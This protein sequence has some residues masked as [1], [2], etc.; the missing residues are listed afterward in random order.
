M[1]LM[2]D[3]Q[4]LVDRQQGQELPEETLRSI[5]AYYQRVTTLARP[6]GHL[7]GAVMGIGVLT[8]LIETVRSGE[9]R[10]V[11]LISL[12]LFGAPALLALL[13]VYPNAVRLGSRADSAAR[14]SALARA[15]HRDHLLCL[16]AML[17]FVA[18]QLFAALR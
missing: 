7:V 5:A 6:M 15:I 10:G 8:L 11:V 2:F 13:R 17:S 9:R 12:F 4:V 1:D 14:Q 16:G 3:V 18:L